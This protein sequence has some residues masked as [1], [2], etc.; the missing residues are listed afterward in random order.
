MTGVTGQIEGAKVAGG[1]GRRGPPE[2]KRLERG[3]K[4]VLFIGF[5]TY[6]HAPGL[7][8]TLYLALQKGGRGTVGSVGCSSAKNQSQINHMILLD[9][10]EEV[11]FVMANIP[12]TVGYF[13]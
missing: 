5:S 1:G 3:Q 10:R 6:Q 12:F 8:I 11:T 13:K 2:S 7:S 4:G 9:Y